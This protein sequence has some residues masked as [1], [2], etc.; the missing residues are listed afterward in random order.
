VEQEEPGAVRVLFETPEQMGAD[1]GTHTGLGV[2]GVPLEGCQ[3]TRLVA[4][5][6]LLE[7]GAGQALLVAEVVVDAAHTGLGPRAHILDRRAHQ[8]VLQEDGE[9]GLEDPL[10]AGVRKRLS[11]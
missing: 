4:G 7:H 3:E 10:A 6:S 2:G 9:R 8:A 1:H 5:Q 11:H